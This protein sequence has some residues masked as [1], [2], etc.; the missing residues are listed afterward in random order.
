M[1]VNVWR[2]RERTMRRRRDEKGRG[3]PGQESGV[4]RKHRVFIFNFRPPTSDLR[5]ADHHKTI[6]RAK[7][8]NTW[9]LPTGDTIAGFTI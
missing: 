6:L 7:T 4:A 3:S 2:I 8:L 1:N 5:P 9:P